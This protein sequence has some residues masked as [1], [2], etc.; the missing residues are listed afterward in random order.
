MQKFE[1][2]ANGT[3]YG[4]YEAE[5]K[6]GALVAHV[7]DAGYKSVQDASETVGQIESDFRSEFRIE[8]A[9]EIKN[10][11]VGLWDDFET[12]VIFFTLLTGSEEIPTLEWLDPDGDL[13]VR[14]SHIKSAHDFGS[15]TIDIIREQLEDYLTAHRD[16]VEELLS[17]NEAA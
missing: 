4:I 14:D 3:S 5:D 6:E 2:I 10:V 8:D 11:R 13:E 16:E 17:D 9:I 1:V 12:P 15:R 7:V